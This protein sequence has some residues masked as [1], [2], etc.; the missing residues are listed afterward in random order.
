MPKV[1]KQGRLTI[2]PTS[3]SEAALYRLLSII[4]RSSVVLS[5]RKRALLKEENPHADVIPQPG[6]VYS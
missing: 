5:A 6:H 3:L 1:F 4:N 2:T